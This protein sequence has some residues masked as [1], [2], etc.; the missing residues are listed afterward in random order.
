MDP[1]SQPPHLWIVLGLAALMLAAQAIFTRRRSGSARRATT[2]LFWLGGAA[3]VLGGMLLRPAQETSVSAGVIAWVLPTAGF[4][5]AA[6]LR[7]SRRDLHQ[8]IRAEVAACSAVDEAGAGVPPELDA[9]DQRLARQLAALMSR[10]IAD[11]MIPAAQATRLRAGHSL[12]EIA[13][14]LRQE[15]VSRLPVLD[16]DGR[17]AIGVVAIKDLL[18][19]LSFG[20]T[21]VAAPTAAELCRPIPTV[22]SEQ[23]VAEVLE[24]LRRE[25]GLAA[26]VDEGGAVTGFISWARIFEALVPGAQP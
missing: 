21:R 11:L 3:W 25:G 15:R 2:L 20:E 7:W 6:L 24:A 13:A 5:V 26:V 17:C 23:R 16:N 8:Y 14:L 18:S 9:D 12:P 1:G 19:R 10:R 4:L 22:T